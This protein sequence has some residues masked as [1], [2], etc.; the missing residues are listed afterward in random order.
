MFIFISKENYGSIDSVPFYTWSINYDEDRIG[1]ISL[2]IRPSDSG[3]SVG[4]Y[5]YR[6]RVGY[7][8]EE[9]IKQIMNDFKELANN[10][11]LGVDE[12][13]G[14]IYVVE[15]VYSDATNSPIFY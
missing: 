8:P 7:I 4:A 14:H 9:T 12:E 5:L 1:T 3:V 11:L 2:I 13:Y 10:K 15:T 6:N